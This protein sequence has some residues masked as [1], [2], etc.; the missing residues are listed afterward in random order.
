MDKNMQQGG[1]PLWLSRLWIRVVTAGLGYC[2]ATDSMAGP[3][4]FHMPWEWLKKKIHAR[5]FLWFRKDPGMTWMKGIIQWDILGFYVDL[6]TDVSGLFSP[7]SR[8][9]VLEAW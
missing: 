3:R 8:Q 7:R 9:G 2:C 4:N 1:A 6:V 5:R